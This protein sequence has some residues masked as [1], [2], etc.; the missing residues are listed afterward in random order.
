MPRMLCN[1]VF[2]LF[3][4]YVVLHWR[5]NVRVV[6]RHKSTCY[7]IAIRSVLLGSWYVACDATV[8]CFT[9]S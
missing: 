6:Q 9:L 3:A 8:C 2:I 1:I 7:N 5:D 4:C